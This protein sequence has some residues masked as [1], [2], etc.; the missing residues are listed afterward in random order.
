[1]DLRKKRGF[2]L[3]GEFY[4]NSG[5]GHE[6]NAI[7]IINKCGWANEWR[8]G[9]AQDFLVLE[10]RAIQIGSGDRYDRIVASR[11]FYSESTIDRVSKK[12]NI[13]DYHLDLIK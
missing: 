13:E 6:G 5:N 10:K 8:T 11:K 4:F 1:M 9:T 7:E 3:N 2:I 12:Y